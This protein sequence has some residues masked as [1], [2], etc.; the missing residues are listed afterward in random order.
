M[1]VGSNP[2]SVERHIGLIYLLD[3]FFSP[4]VSNRGAL[5]TISIVRNRHD[6]MR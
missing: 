5:V 3:V 2:A 4:I 1:A 6:K